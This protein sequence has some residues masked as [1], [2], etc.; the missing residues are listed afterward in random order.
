MRQMALAFVRV[1]ASTEFP[2]AVGLAMSACESSWWKAATGDFNFWGTTRNPESGTAKFCATSEYVTATE[3]AT[4]R[5]DER[6]TAVPHDV[7]ADGQ[8]HWLKISRWFASYSSL[9]ESIH[10]FVSLITKSPHRYTAAWQ[11]Y[12]QDRDADALLAH[13]CDAGYATGPAKGVELSILHQQN[14]IHAVAAAR[15]ELATSPQAA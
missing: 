10:D 2:A 8:K 3:L 15:A 9:E 12:L 7:P 14:I 1:E 5:P 13:I 4:F 11:Q 6:A